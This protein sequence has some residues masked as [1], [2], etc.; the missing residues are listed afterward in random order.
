MAAFPFVTRPTEL[1]LQH[2]LNARHSSAGCDLCSTLCPAQAVTLSGN[3][4]SLDLDR[5]VG[6]GLCLHICP[7]E[8]FEAPYWSERTPVANIAELND[9]VDLFCAHH[10]RPETGRP[11]VGSLQIPTCLAAMSPGSWFEMGLDRAVCARLD[12]CA[13]CPLAGV[14]G[15]IRSA[16]DVANDWLR[17]SGH[18]A[19]ITCLV[20]SA[21]AGAEVQRPVLS[22]EHRRVSRRGF[23][24]MLFASERSRAGR[25]Q[26]VFDIPW[27][28]QESPK[29]TPRLPAWMAHAASVFASRAQAAPEAPVT[30]WPSITVGADCVTCDAC[31]DYC[32][33]GALEVCVE[34]DRYTIAFR[35]G[36]CVDC[37]ICWASCPVGTITRSQASTASPFERQPIMQR[38]IA[39]C[40]QCGRPAAEGTICYW[41]GEEPPL[42][43]V[44]TDARRWLLSSSIACR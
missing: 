41:C 14:S 9:V 6:C 25:A 28:G 31:T 33:T 44:M 23:F 24:K 13:D 38:P 40:A 22:G 42:A 18:D 10:P 39:S 17:D 15:E 20:M 30:A 21:D 11:D 26:N 35:P 29:K 3:S 8:V 43:V 1:H 27:T 5:C 2:C 34:A 12:A 7:A 4:V 16:T 37:R 36:Q 32:P 19:C